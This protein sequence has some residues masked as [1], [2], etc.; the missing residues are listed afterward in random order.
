MNSSK[1]LTAS[2]QDLEAA[3]AFVPHEAF[4]HFL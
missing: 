3:H 4:V 2:K 1:A